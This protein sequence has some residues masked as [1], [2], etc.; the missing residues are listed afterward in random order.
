MKSLF[1]RPSA[2]GSFMIRVSDTPFDPATELQGFERAADGAGAIVSFLGKVRAKG[3]EGGVRA[4]Y[5]EHY[6]GVTERT[7][8]DIERETHERWAIEHTLII[9]RVGGMRPGEPIVLVCVAAA[10]RRAAFEA[11][12]FL[13]DY[14]KTEAMFWKKEVS[15]NGETWIEPREDDYNDAARWREGRG[16][17]DEDG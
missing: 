8:A 2:A 4:L 9:H 5:L 6:P 13:M 12:D 16:A 15:A 17:Q 7:I 1:C 3:D 14:L 10:H 11:A